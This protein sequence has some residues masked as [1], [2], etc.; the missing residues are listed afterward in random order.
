MPRKE[1]VLDLVERR[2]TVAL[3]SPCPDS[4]LLGE[5]QMGLLEP[6]QAAGVGQHVR[7]C[8]LCRQEL[9]QMVA[10]MEGPETLAST[11]ETIREV[12]LQWGRSALQPSHGLALAG[13]RGGHGRARTFAADH[14]WLAVTIQEGDNGNKNLLA[15]VTRSDG[16][17]LEHGIAWLSRQNQLLSGGRVDEAGNLVITDIPPGEYDLGIQ[18]DGTRVWVRGVSV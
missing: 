14:L 10:F 17:P 5:Y 8:P 15:L 16:Y 11:I 4:M 9:Q 13:V 2:L 18:C 3:Q 6:G 12:A 1:S 7:A